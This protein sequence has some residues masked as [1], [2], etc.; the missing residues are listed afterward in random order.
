MEEEL[1]GQDGMVLGLYRKC[2]MIKKS[3]VFVY[4]LL[5]GQKREEKYLY[6]PTYIGQQLS[7]TWY[8]Y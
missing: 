4:S 5:L 6:A 8:N 7:I 3:V 1:G 2:T